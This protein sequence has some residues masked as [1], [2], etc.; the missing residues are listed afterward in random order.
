VLTAEKQSHEKGC[1][2]SVVIGPLSLVPCHLGLRRAAQARR[3]MGHEGA[4]DAEGTEV[5][6]AIYGRRGSLRKREKPQARRAAIA[7]ILAY[8]S[9]WR[10]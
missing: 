4:E 5:Y 1:H 6:R 10:A 8:A 2:W 3:H 7:S 9:D